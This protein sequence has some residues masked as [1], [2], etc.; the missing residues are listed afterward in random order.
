[1]NTQDYMSLKPNSSASKMF[2]PGSTTSSSI[3]QKMRSRLKSNIDI[4]NTYSTQPNKSV[5]KEQP[6]KERPLT[7]QSKGKTVL[8]TFTA[9]NLLILD[10]KRSKTR[11]KSKTKTYKNSK[12]KSK[13]S[14][15]P[16]YRAMLRH[17]SCDH[18][19]TNSTIQILGQNSYKLSKQNS[20]KLSTH[21]KNVKMKAQRSLKGS[22]SKGGKR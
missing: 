14:Q 8:Y 5:A 10:S 6:H 1:M 3:M 2:T 12:S 21:L 13:Q 9:S 7:S 17:N 19:S 18:T 22:K 20:S 4:I 16:L 15:P 11:S